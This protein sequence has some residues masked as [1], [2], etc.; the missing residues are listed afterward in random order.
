MTDSASSGTLN[1]TIIWLPVWQAATVD[2]ILAVLPSL[3][4]LLSWV[5]VLFG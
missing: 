5:K 1:S 2:I 3:L 4:T